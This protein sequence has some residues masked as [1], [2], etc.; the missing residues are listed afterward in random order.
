MREFGSASLGLGG[1]LLI[2]HPNLLDPNFR[3]TVLFLAAN[4]PKAGSFGL[5]LN[6]ST[7]KNVS[8]F[9][10]DEEAAILSEVPVFVGGPV[11]RNE[12]TFAAFSVNDDVVECRT[13][14]DIADARELA[15][16]KPGVLRA[17]IG[18]SGWSEGQLEAELSQKA[19]LVQRPDHDVLNLEKCQQL[20]QTIMREHGPWFR[21]LAAAPDDPSKN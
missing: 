19:W 2:A 20:W 18:H 14:L 7:G 1:S 10:A 8:E 3:R 15:D 4:D 21:L 12:L 6:R 16:E 13:H 5:I 11:G 9:L 17:F